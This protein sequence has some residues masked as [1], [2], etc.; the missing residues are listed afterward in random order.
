M[1]RKYVIAGN[2]KM[3]K[4]PQQAYKLIEEIKPLV[5]NAACDVIVAVPFV[6]IPAPLKP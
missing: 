1:S 6:D 3:N 4:N 5:T 2:W